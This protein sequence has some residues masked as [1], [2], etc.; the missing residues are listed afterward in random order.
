[1]ADVKISQL[2]S[3]GGNLISNDLIPACTISPLSTVQTT[4]ENIISNSYNKISVRQS[5]SVP[6]GTHNID[7]PTMTVPSGYF[8]VTGTL[9][10][11]ATITPDE[12]LL[13]PY[14]NGTIL[15]NPGSIT[16]ARHQNM[17]D[18]AQTTSTN[19]TVDVGHNVTALTYVNAGSYSFRY[20]IFLGG[21]IS[22][23]NTFLPS[24]NYIITC[25]FFPT[26]YT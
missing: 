10:A 13:V 16:L 26:S 24:N 6:Q 22:N 14:S 4:V 1:M 21:A 3:F 9:S 18:L 12:F 11:T 17:P 5:N 7:I 15:R 25:S 8:F 20:R 23:P 19:Y 2:P